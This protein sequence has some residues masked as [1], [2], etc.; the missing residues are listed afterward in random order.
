MMKLRLLRLPALTLL[1]GALVLTAC[2]AASGKPTVVI[3][4]PPSGSTFT[5]GDDVAVQSTSADSTGVSRVELTVDGA[6]VRNDT[7]PS[8]QTN[9][10]LIQ[11]WKATQGNHTLIVRAYNA[12]GTASDPASILVQVNA[13]VAQNIPTSTPVAGV[14]PTSAPAP[15]ASPTSAVSTGAVTGQV[16]LSGGPSQPA[17]NATVALVDAPTF[18]TVT[19]SDGSYT[20]SNVPAGPHIVSALTSQGSS[21]PV[22]INVPA[23]GSAAANLVIFAAFPTPTSAVP[24]PPPPSCSGTPNI[25]SFTASPSSITDGQSTTLSWGLVSNANSAEIDHGIGGV[26]TPDSKKV[27]PNSTTTFTLTALCGSNKTTAQVTVTVTP[28][29][30]HTP[31]AENFGGHWV[32]NFGTMDITQ[33]G[34]NVVGLFHNSVD[35]GDGT[36]TGTVSANTLTGDWQRSLSGTLQF[37]LNSGGNSFDGNWNTTEQ[38]CGARSGTNFPSGCGFTGSWTTAYDPPNGATSCSMSLTQKDSSVTGTYCNGTIE[39]GSITFISGF[40]KLTGTWHFENVNSGPFQFYLP[41]YTSTQ[42]QGDY[43]STLDWCGY[44]GGAA[45]PSPCEK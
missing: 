18:S 32:T 37:K 16:L 4:S 38:W 2:T 25:A 23:G 15:G 33:N 42:F 19:G 39:N 7:P 21:N 26:K 35:V 44:R 11:T 41:A 30:T 24:P 3:S 29:P 9:L 40:V 31:N 34:A 28:A 22:N 12:A 14:P 8:T 5:E 20:L 6:V 36:I 17:A 27:S 1:L 13:S 43:N 10:P 45:K